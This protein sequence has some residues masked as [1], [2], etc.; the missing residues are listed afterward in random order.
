[1]AGE[2]AVLGLGQFGRSVATSLAQHNESVLAVDQKMERVETVEQSVDAAVR[3]DVADESTLHNLDIDQMTTVIVAIGAHS[4][5]ASIMTTALLAQMGTPNIIARSSSDLHAR[6]LRQV[7]AHE[8][9]NPEGEMGARVARRLSKPS[10]V[11][12][13]ELGDSIIA[14]VAVPQSITGRSLKELELRNQYEISVI[15]IQRGDDVSANPR[16]TATLE[17]EDVLVVIGNQNNVD[18]FAALA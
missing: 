9:L 5:E 2:F 12:Q 18:D 14:E 8:V 11:D 10:V 17:E 13:F 3:A 6:I 1:M 16:A 7:G 15:A 4:T